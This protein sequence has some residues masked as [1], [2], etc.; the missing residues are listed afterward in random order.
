M[1]APL[2][3]L[4]LDSIATAHM[5]SFRRA[6]AC[7]LRRPST[8]AARASLAALLLDSIAAA[9]LTSFRRATHACFPRPPSLAVLRATAHRTSFGRTN[10]RGARPPDE[11]RARAYSRHA[12]DE[13][14][15]RARV[16]ARR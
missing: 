3:A 8:T 16:G 12:P 9:H 10:T 15:A 13:L 5:T 11:L 4:L 6:G 14:R 7:S 2:A 1:R